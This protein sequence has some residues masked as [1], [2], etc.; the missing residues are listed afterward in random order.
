M[1]INLS[2][3]TPLNNPIALFSGTDDSMYIRSFAKW[4]D[5][6]YISIKRKDYDSMTMMM[7]I[8]DEPWKSQRVYLEGTDGF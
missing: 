6:D 7:D 4:L 2:P 1:A 8:Y 3:T 5:R